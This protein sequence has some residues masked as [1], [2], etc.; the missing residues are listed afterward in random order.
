MQSRVLNQRRLQDRMASNQSSILIQQAW[1][2]IAV[3]T[4][5]I[6]RTS[7]R[8][9]HVPLPWKES[10]AIFVAKPG[11]TDYYRAKSYR[12]ITL[13]PVLLK[14]QEKV[15]LW[16]MQF[17]L[18]MTSLT[19]EHQ[20]GFKKGSSTETA[21]HKVVHK[22]EKWIAKKGY[23]LGTFLDIGH[24]GCLWQCVIQCYIHSY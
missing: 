13:S 19:S 5:N 8:L 20:Y 3:I 17:D 12:P 18:N 4:R 10:K 24:R 6:M 15:I 2:Q 11:K 7:H 21:L 14:L 22:I 1:D 23:V 9:Q 16:H